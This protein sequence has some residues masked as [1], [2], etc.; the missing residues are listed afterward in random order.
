MIVLDT[1]V[2]S[3]TMRP[4]PE[5]V[6]VDWLRAQAVESVATTV[7][8]ESELRLGA[9][10]LDPGARRDRLLALIDT[11]MRSFG[12]RLLPIDLDVPRRYAELLSRRLANGRPMTMSDALIAA[13]CLQHGSSLATRNTRDFE[14]CGIA[15]IN[16]WATKQ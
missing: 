6:V 1:N 9:L 7:V 10:R 13:I 12:P 15:L 2:L 14:G 11:Q 5:P 4:R 16:P 3:E 8:S